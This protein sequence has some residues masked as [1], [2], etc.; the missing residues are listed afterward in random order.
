MVGAA[1]RDTLADP[2]AERGLL[3]Q[4]LPGDVT[5]V[6]GLVGVRAVRDAFELDTDGQADGVDGAG[7]LLQAR[8]IDEQDARDGVEGD[9]GGLA[10]G[11]LAGGDV[12]E[13]GD[14]G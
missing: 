8:L 1:A 11:L 4:Q 13:L 6:A 10:P 12:D 2:P 9:L 3:V 14:E 5:R 7:D